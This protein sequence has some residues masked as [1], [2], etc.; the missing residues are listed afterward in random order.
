MNCNDFLERLQRCLDDRVRPESDRA[1]VRHTQQCEHCRRQLATWHQVSLLMPTG[2]V[3]TVDGGNGTSMRKPLAGLAAA[4]LLAFVLMTSLR[5]RDPG[6]ATRRDLRESTSAQV[7]D[8]DQP[9]SWVM[10]DN[11]LNPADWWQQ[12]NHREWVGQ[13]MPT[14]RSMKQGVAPLGRTLMRAVTILTTGGR[15]QAS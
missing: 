7:L 2:S 6:S 11:E 4:A 13:T 3:D 15:D 5:D 10:A 14:V 8:G 9:R 1:I 12:V